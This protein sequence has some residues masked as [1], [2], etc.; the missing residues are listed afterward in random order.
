[1]LHFPLSYHICDIKKLCVLA[2]GLELG[3]RVQLGLGPGEDVPATLVLNFTATLIY[4]PIGS[5]FVPQ[6]LKNSFAAGDARWRVHSVTPADE[7][8][9]CPMSNRALC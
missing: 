5:K 8:R 2:L 7:H 9:L 4:N 6:K 1:M 3:V